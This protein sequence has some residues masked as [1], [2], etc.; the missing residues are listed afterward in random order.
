MRGGAPSVY[1][2]I[3]INLGLSADETKNMEF[4]TCLFLIT[5]AATIQALPSGHLQSRRRLWLQHHG[6]V[7]KPVAA[8]ADRPSTSSTNQNARNSRPQKIS[9]RKLCGTFFAKNCSYDSTVLQKTFWN[10]YNLSMSHSSPILQ[11]LMN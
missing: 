4:R 7:P 9:R 6:I 11:T 2:R 1:V 5:F 8:S 3:T 10:K